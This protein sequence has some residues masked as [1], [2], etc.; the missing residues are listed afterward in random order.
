[1][2][3]ARRGRGC[4][5]NH[6]DYLVGRRKS[7]RSKVI[8]KVA[9]ALRH[10]LRDLGFEQYGSSFCRLRGDVWQTVS[11]FRHE[12]FINNEFS[13]SGWVVLQLDAGSH[14]VREVLGRHALALTGASSRT[15][16][17][18]QD[19]LPASVG[20]WV[21]SGDMQLVL[22][23]IKTRLASAIPQ[24]F[25]AR[26]SNR[27]LRQHSIR[28]DIVP[29]I[30]HAL[31][32]DHQATA[33]ACWNL[34]NACMARARHTVGATLFDLAARFLAWQLSANDWRLQV[35]LVHKALA[36]AD[37]TYKM[38]SRALSDE[39]YDELARTAVTVAD[40]LSPR[41][42]DEQIR[43]ALEV[44]DSPDPMMIIKGTI[45]GRHDLESK[46]DRTTR[47]RIT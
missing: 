20:H 43:E 44:Y 4:K 35:R 36:R 40:G 27:Q 15:P 31:D 46:V 42:V 41:E 10:F 16:Q 3:P 6:S 39:Y 13:P 11:I 38:D 45:Y 18:M 5:I 37:R 25:D 22:S 47:I 2:G 34:R 24:F 32:G 12:G 21:C 33:L 1:M 8:A 14:T 7:M 17:R 30:L 9:A 29:A 28:R 23:D 19:V 26:S